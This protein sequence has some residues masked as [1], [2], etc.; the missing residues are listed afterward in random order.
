MIATRIQP[1]IEKDVDSLPWFAL[2]VK[3]RH[4][5]RVSLHLESRG[6]EGLVPLYLKRTP[7]RISELPLFPGYVFSRFNFNQRQPVMSVPGVFSLVKTG[8]TPVPISNQEIF[9]LQQ[10]VR[11]K[12]PR[13]PHP[14]LESGQ[15]VTITTGPLRGV[16]G[17]FIESKT[18]GTLIVSVEVLRR[19]VAVEVDGVALSWPKGEATGPTALPQ[20]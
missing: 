15:R 5:K 8:N 13:Q 17:T 1:A 2:Y 19:S 6:Y 7:Q 11:S 10:L 4:E 20:P 18:R 14:Y 3:P 12:V 9:N 16:E